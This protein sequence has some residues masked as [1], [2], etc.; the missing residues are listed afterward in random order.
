MESARGLKKFVKSKTFV[1]LILVAIMWV[2]FSVLSEG[3]YTSLINIRNILNSIVITILLTIGAVYLMIDGHIDLSTSMVGSMT[4]LM[5]AIFLT[6][7]GWPWPIA[8]IACLAVAAVIGFANAVLINEFRFQPFIATMAMASVVKGLTYVFCG[9][10][11]ITI[12]DPAMVALGTSRIGGFV[13]YTIILALVIILIYGIIL[14]KTY[15]GKTIYMIGGN[16]HAA[17]LAGLNPKKMSYILFINNAIL[18]GFAGCLLAFRLTSGTVDAVTNSQFLG[19]TGAILGGVSF[20]GG[21]G[22]MGGAFVGM[23]LLNGFSNGLTV[24]GLP[25]YWQNFGSG[26]LLLLALMFDYFSVRRQLKMK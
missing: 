8:I 16:K 23:I 4:S 25:V 9:T 22:G 5:V 7:Y 1:L 17:R 18:G 2:I 11:P 10:A 6:K 26:A 12:K 13:P 3:A 20:G 15:F 14:S 19:M 21:S 24:L